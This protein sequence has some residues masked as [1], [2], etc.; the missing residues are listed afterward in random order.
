MIQDSKVT[1]SFFT[2]SQFVWTFLLPLGLKQYFPKWATLLPWGG[3]GNIKGGGGVPRGTT[4]RGYFLSA[5]L[6]IGRVPEKQLSDFISEKGE[7]RPLNKFGDSNLEPA[8]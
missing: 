1:D 7:N 3:T 8:K 2:I 6:K 5:C 4:G